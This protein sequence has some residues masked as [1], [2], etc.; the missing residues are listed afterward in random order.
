[1]SVFDLEAARQIAVADDCAIV[2]DFRAYSLSGLRIKRRALKT[3]VEAIT[4][5][6]NRFTIF[7][8]FLL[9]Q[10]SLMPSLYLVFH[11]KILHFV[12]FFHT[13][14]Q[15]APLQKRSSCMRRA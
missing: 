8:L 13:R 11:G 7:I 9:S 10:I 4:A 5:D 2:T 12:V 15:A 3:I 6:N 1:M 14:F